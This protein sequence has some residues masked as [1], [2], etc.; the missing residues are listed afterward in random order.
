MRFIFTAEPVDLAQFPKSIPDYESVGAVWSSIEELADL[1][2]RG[3]EPTIYFPYVARNEP[4]YPLSA[5]VTPRDCQ[6]IW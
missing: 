1:K 2:L 5:I 4:I 3:S 6:R